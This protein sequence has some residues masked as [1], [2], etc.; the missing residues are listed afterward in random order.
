MS[1][2]QRDWV[3]RKFKQPCIFWDVDSLDWKLR[4]AHQTLTRVVKNV[5]KGSLI[6]LHS[7]HLE[8]VTA[9]SLIIDELKKRGYQFSSSE[10]DFGI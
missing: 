7:T 3:F 2:E 1:L 8:S 6:L 4:D 10:S 5:R 9:T